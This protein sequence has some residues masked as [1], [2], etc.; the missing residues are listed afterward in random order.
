LRSVHGNSA[1]ALPVCTIRRVQ[2]YVG[3]EF[4]I[5][6][7]PNWVSFQGLAPYRD[8][9][10]LFPIEKSLRVLDT[11]PNFQIRRPPMNTIG[12]PFL[13]RLLLIKIAL[14]EVSDLGL[15]LDSTRRRKGARV[16]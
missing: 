12:E 4:R 7:G 3:I 5:V 16:L 15:K 9:M 11:L 6:F 2:Q 10:S 8:C 1:S 13:L 14:Q